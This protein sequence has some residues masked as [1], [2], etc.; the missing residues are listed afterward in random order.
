[1]ESDLLDTFGWRKDERPDDGRLGRIVRVDRGEC[2]VVTEEGQLRVLSDSQRSQGLVA[3]ATGD[4]VVVVD[5]LELGPVISRVLERTNTVSRR[6]PSEEVVEQVLVANV[7]LV[8]IVHGLD[9]PL[10]VGRLERFLVVGW[11]SGAEV[12]VVLTKA[13]SEPTAALEVAATVRALAPDIEVLTV[14][15]GDDRSGHDLVAALMEPGKTVALLGESGAGKSTLINALVGDE[16]LAT[17]AVRASDAKGRHTTVSRELV[18]R[19]GGG[20]LVDTPG[21][22]AVGI[23]DAE[24]SLARVFGDLEERSTE[25]RFADC[26]HDAEP[27]CA[28]R[29]EVAAGRVDRRRVERYR[30]LRSELAEQRKREVDRERRVSRGRRR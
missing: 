15:L 23:W 6:D 16:L 28:V 30:S 3:P 18:L 14:G 29:S 11:D 13:D 19:P 9:R 4:W 24:D 8:L 12:V 1:M 21:I 27:D 22:R 5:D 10:P 25:C 7:D 20:L 17:G 2:D 26:V